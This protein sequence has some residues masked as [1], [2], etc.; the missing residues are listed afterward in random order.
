MKVPGRK[1]GDAETK[2]DRAARERST[3]DADRSQGD[4]EEVQSG[5]KDP[6]RAGRIKRRSDGGG[7]VPT[8]RDP[9]QHL[10]QVDEGVHGS[11]ESEIERGTDAG[12]N[13]GRSGSAEA[14]KR[15]TKRSGRRP[16]RR[17]THAQKKSLLKTRNHYQRQTA[18][19]KLEIC[20]QVD[21]STLSVNKTL[22]KLGIPKSTY[23]RWQ[24]QGPWPSF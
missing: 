14:G 23:Y 4:T 13:E 1:Q 5:R 2:E 22:R 8:G 12:C 6:D 3:T 15:A 16:D 11:G 9:R 10:L 17:S 20:R 19:Q 18:E 21:R 7:T 24:H